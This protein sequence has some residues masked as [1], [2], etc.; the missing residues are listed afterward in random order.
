M[1]ECDNRLLWLVVMLLTVFVATAAVPGDTIECDG[2]RYVVLEGDSTL[3][4]VSPGGGYKGSTIVIP[5]TVENGKRYIVTEIASRAFY[6]NDSLTALSLPVT[7]T[8]IGAEAFAGDSNLRG[9][10]VI[11]EGV[12]AIGNHAFAFCSTLT[13]FSLPST[14]L[15]VGAGVLEGCSSVD[16]IFCHVPNPSL[17]LHELPRGALLCV[18]KDYIEDYGQYDGSLKILVDVDAEPRSANLCDVNRDGYVSAV[19]VTIVYN[20]LLGYDMTQ[21][22]A[23]ADGDGVITSTDVT[24]IYS[25]LLEGNSSGVGDRGYCFA[26]IDTGSGSASLR[27]NEKLRLPVGSEVG[28]V[29][30]DNEQQSFVSIG[31]N[32]MSGA[33]PFVK[34]INLDS[35]VQA[36]A[37]NNKSYNTGTTTQAVMHF[38]VT[39]DTIYYKDVSV[40]MARHVVT[41]TLCV[42]SIGNSF[43]LDALSYVPFIIKAV[44]PQV[45]LKLGIM[46][47]GGGG[48][49]T[50]YYALDT[51]SFRYYWSY[52]AQPW[53]ERLGVSMTE[54]I[55]SQPWDVIT[56]Q[57]K[58]MTSR[59][60]STYQPYLNQL[61]GWLDEHATA[62]HEYAWLITPSYSEGLDR[63]APD[64]TSVQMFERIIEC[65]RNMQNDTGIELLLPCG[66]AI[67]NAR[68]TPLDSLGDLGHLFEYLHL[69]DGIPCLIEA[70]VA[71]AALLARY[72]LS[73]CVWTDTTWVDQQWLRD[74]NI[75]EINGLP[76]GMSEEN[77]AIAKQCAIKALENPLSI[78]MIE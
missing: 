19:D 61:I 5:A 71:S 54:I 40:E 63:L 11:P 17:V 66:T 48:L 60:Y 65:V 34:T 26:I 59:D 7:L 53:D 1:R 38:D 15:R 29:A 74:K 50:F 56:L 24:V 16:T 39:P 12:T 18:D 30:L 68:T 76:V 36:V 33:V 9:S 27:V 14:L 73:E 22:H 31:F 67:Q 42:L 6:Q 23:D 64:T 13:S 47:I 75:Q 49:D 28:V 4:L 78:T 3:S 77:R 55:E 8:S 25:A 57:Q 2:L 37:L 35:G 69:Q 44:A 52:G 72:G 32:V 21:S 43:S 58:S 45:Y 10:I 51:D 41:D 46:Y 62:P 70:Y 20:Y